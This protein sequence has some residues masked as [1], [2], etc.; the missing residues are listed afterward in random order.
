MR[1]R[2]ER[3]LVV[4]ETK[5]RPKL[6]T[7]TAAKVFFFNHHCWQWN[8]LCCVGGPSLDL[9]SCHGEEHWYQ[10]VWSNTCKQ[11]RHRLVHL[12]CAYLFHP[13]YSYSIQMY[14]CSCC[15]DNPQQ[16]ELSNLVV[17]KVNNGFIPAGQSP[18]I[19]IQPLSAGA[20]NC[21]CSWTLEN[22]F[23]SKI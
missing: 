23:W 9:R 18:D 6:W 21:L 20:K 11:W 13:H 10:S 3:R 1:E 8:N 2:K 19:R 15:S 7:Q 4:G 17:I 12:I 14:F 22:N 16:Q 5:E